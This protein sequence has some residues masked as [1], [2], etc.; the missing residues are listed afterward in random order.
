MSAG[1]VSDKLPSV[2]PVP[3]KVSG[4]L[5]ADNDV[6]MSRVSES[7]CSSVTAKAFCT[8]LSKT[9]D[10]LPFP[11]FN[12]TGREW[13]SKAKAHLRLQIKT[14]LTAKEI[15]ITNSDLRKWS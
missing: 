14:V 15:D 5:P 10:H 8:R 4:K 2:D 7:S 13:D 3:V 11:N 1:R 9:F 12:V 6:S